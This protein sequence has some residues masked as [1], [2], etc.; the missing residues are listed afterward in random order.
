M[1]TPTPFP[2]AVFAGRSALIVEDN[3]FMR[4]LVRSLLVQFGFDGI[5]EAT[6]GSQAL[7]LVAERRFDVVICDWLMEPSDGYAFLR[8][9]RQHEDPVVRSVP[10]IM[11]TSVANEADVLA[12]RDAGVT[13][14]L[15]KPVSSGK[16][17]D[18]L[19][20]VFARPR[21][22]VVTDGY[23]G[24]DRRR[25]NDPDRRAAGRRLSD[26]LAR[27]APPD[28]GWASLA[29]DY[30]GVLRNEAERL[31][32]SL[33]EVEASGGAVLAPWLTVRGIAHDIVGHAST[34]GYTAAAAIAASLE[35]LVQ[36]AVSAPGTLVHGTVRRLR[37]AQTHAKALALILDQGIVGRSEETDA[38]VARL[39]RTVDR[40]H[41]DAAA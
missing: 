33:V 22:F 18:R 7:L 24:P 9:L 28:D 6:D 25:R 17:R 3:P 39:E 10:V 21:G 38:L 36:P 16:L 31:R 27:N 8:M 41:R 12:A 29:A 37:A 2:N 19:G 35:R 32:A 4:R 20:A 14:Y 34:F 15:V 30:P 23:V 5:E 11:L 40:V 26:R 1:T 13:E